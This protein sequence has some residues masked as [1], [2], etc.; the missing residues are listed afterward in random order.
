MDLIDY[1]PDPCCADPTYVMTVH[2]NDGRFDVSDILTITIDNVRDMPRFLNIQDPPVTP[3]QASIS[4]DSPG[5]MAIYGV[6][7]RKHL[8]LSDSCCN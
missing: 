8:H 1:V 2:A 4:E 6:N 5:G 7:S 3:S